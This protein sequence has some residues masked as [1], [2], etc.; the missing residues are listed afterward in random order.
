MLALVSPVF[1][2]FLGGL[3]EPVLVSRQPDDL[4][5]RKAFRR[6]RG[7]SVLVSAATSPRLVISHEIRTVGKHLISNFYNLGKMSG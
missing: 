1:C 5:R 2:N 6:I 7:R 4:D 3:G